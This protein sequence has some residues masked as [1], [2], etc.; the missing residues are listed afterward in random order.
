MSR[1]QNC[2]R[3]RGLVLLVDGARKVLCADCANYFSETGSDVV[4]GF[5][6]RDEQLRDQE[7]RADI[8]I[9]DR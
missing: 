4:A 1:C 9:A 8:A 6:E 5:D 3:G 7:R 2:A